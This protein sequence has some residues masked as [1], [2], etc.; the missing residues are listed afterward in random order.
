MDLG[1]GT[2]AEIGKY[3]AGNPR[4]RGSILVH[5][6]EP[7][8]VHLQHLK[9]ALARHQLLPQVTVHETAAWIADEQVHRLCCAVLN[10]GPC[11]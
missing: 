11:L 9:A 5:A 4:Q 3:F 8:A 7:Y 2:G 10:V 6:F 1:S